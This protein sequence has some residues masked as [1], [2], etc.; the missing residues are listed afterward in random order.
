MTKPFGYNPVTG[1]YEPQDETPN[2]H[3]I[4]ESIRYNRSNGEYELFDLV[5][6]KWNVVAGVEQKIYLNTLYG[7]EIHKVSSKTDDMPVLRSGNSKEA[8]SPN[9]KEKGTSDFPLNNLQSLSD[10]AQKR[11]SGPC[12]FSGSV[13]YSPVSERTETERNA[14]A[15][16]F[17]FHPVKND[18]QKLK[19]EK[20]RALAKE[21]ALLIYDETPLCREQSASLTHLDEV[22]MFANAAIARHE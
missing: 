6:L 12:P 2:Y 16:R 7:E 9:Q 10:A 19:Y 13:A 1:L 3:Q 20:I 8:Q 22:V 21:L 15:D 17:V 5:G 18:E 4:N 14:I 11:H